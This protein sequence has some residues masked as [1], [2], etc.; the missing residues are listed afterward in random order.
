MGE[1]I[2]NIEI[3]ETLS[4]NRFTAVCRGRQT[5]HREPVI[6]KILKPE[7]NTAEVASR[8]RREF[9]ITAGLNI[10]GVVKAIGLEEENGGLMMVMEDIGGKSLDRML[11][12]SPLKLA[13]SLELAIALAE[14]L[15]SL[16]SQDIIHKNID[17][18]NI[19]INPET[20]VVNLIDFATSTKLP[21]ETQKIRHPE[22]IEGALEFISPEQT[23]RMNRTIDYRSDL[24]SLGVVIYTMLSGWPPFQSSD[25]MELIHCH[26]AQQP[27]P[28]CKV[29]PTVPEVVSKIV[30]KLLSKAAEDRY[31]SAYGLKT[32]LEIALAQHKETGRIQSFEIGKSD[33]LMRFQIPEKLY[34]RENEIETLMKGFTAVSRG[35]K[36]KMLMT[37]CGHPGIGKSALV[38][39]IHKPLVQ[40]RGYY[41]LGKFDQLNRDV[42]YSA[43]IEAFQNLINQ[44]LSESS[45]KLN[46]WKFQLLEA[47]DPYGQVIIDVIPELELIIDRQP[48]VPLLPPTESENRFNQLFSKFVSVFAKKD[49][50]LVIF[51]DDLQWGDLASLNLLKLLLRSVELHHFLILGAYRNNEVGASHPL[52]ITIEEI[53]KAGTEVENIVLGPL[54]KKDLLQLTTDTFHCQPK[55]ARP[56]VELLNH[57]TNG[58]PF[59]VVQFLKM[60]HN[61]K[62]VYFTHND[63]QWQWDIGEINKQGIT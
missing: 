27:E 14:I 45:S 38:N 54:S 7:A 48:A 30:D 13:E 36:D 32:D 39:E 33:V 53:E 49:H 63:Q 15:G 20:R 55:S 10:P 31:Q 40:E 6:L 8:F 52:I 9:E 35:N 12:Q 46:S 51:L 11:M 19:I 21:H 22:K 3:T 44:I 1:T 24:Y 25:P 59:F 4:E 42:P 29:N 60:L 17:P 37:V 61:E 57:K 62:L 50:P 16:H 2:K 34:G 43:I 56:L 28:L 23:G 18:T 26:I 41:I 5:E 47:L 58:N